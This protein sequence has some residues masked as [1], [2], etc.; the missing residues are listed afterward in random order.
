MP[1]RGLIRVFDTDE[2]SDAPAEL[3][4]IYSQYDSG[5]DDLGAQLTEFCDEARLCH[6]SELSKQPAN[7]IAAN[8]MG[9][10]AALLIVHL[11]EGWGGIYC[12]RAGS[13]DLGEE[14]EYWISGRFGHSPQ[15]QQ[16]RVTGHGDQRTL[17]PIDE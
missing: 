5:P 9:C 14:F 17:I 11:K 12:F 8:G 2:K 16:F 15:L 10:L 7:T 3:L 1:T 13:K 6:S 4:C